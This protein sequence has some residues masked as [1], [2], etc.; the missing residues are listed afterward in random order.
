MTPLVGPM[1]AEAPKDV[2]FRRLAVAPDYSAEH[3]GNILA[4]WS[5]CS[6]PLLATSIEK[7]DDVFSVHLD[8]SLPW[9]KLPYPAIDVAWCPFK[10]GDSYASFLTA[11]RSCPLQLWDTDDASLRASYVCHN[12]LGKP[13]GPHSLLWSRCRTSIVGGY[14]GA[15]DHVHVRL[16]DVLREGS[17][18]QASYQSPCS[19]GIV[20]ALADGPAPYKESLLLA[21]FVRSGNVDVI[22]TRH[23]G[24]AAVLRGL[25]SGAAQIQAHPTSEY[26]VYAAGR[27]G[28]NRIV[29]W[30][31]RKS[32]QIL[33]FVERKLCTQQPA[34][35]GFL[36]SQEGGRRGH[37]VSATHDG[38]ILVFDA[39]NAAAPPRRMQ[40]S[41]GPTAG[42]AVLED[43]GAVIVT[44]GKRQYPV[45][46]TYEANGGELKMCMRRGKR[47]RAPLDDSES[48]AENESCGEECAAGVAVLKV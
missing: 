20:S 10:E 3:N 28:D 23:L 6:V 31:L 4:T 16:Y 22:D 27:L 9:V 33:F 47:E 13:E 17:T 37:L 2:L 18:A 30:D 44:V 24:A 29:C 15:D 39:D 14:G 42:L 36:P 19:K 32:N 25:R 34:F 35:F 7:G 12:A 38:G 46:D 48:E 45:R 11:C 5:N 26:L 43:E 21:G 1:V 41:L 8:R 40:A